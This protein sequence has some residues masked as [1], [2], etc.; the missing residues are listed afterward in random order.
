MPRRGSSNRE[1][2]RPGV[3]DVITGTLLYI[4]RVPS[5]NK[6][7]TDQIKLVMIDDE[8]DE[9][10]NVWVTLRIGELLLGAGLIEEKETQKGDPY[11][12]P[13]DQPRITVGAEK[14][15]KG[16]KQY[17][18]EDENGDRLD[19]T[20]S[21]DGGSSR[22]ES[23]GSGGGGRRTT[24]KVADVRDALA[25]IN[26]NLGAAVKIAKLHETEVATVFIEIMKE[27]L[28][29]RELA[30][31]EE[32]SRMRKPTNDD[33]DEEEEKPRSRTRRSRKPKEKEEKQESFDDF[34]EA[35]EENDDDDDLPF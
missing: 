11:L 30:A 14:G 35:L 12:K 32:N 19:Q 24:R 23:R 28:D 15:D 31:S 20:A 25:R 3:G 13:V 10:V 1:D 7:Y 34:P 4:D 17:Y 6:K 21:L 5:K 22:S 27:G 9:E 18:V 2:I 26:A 8:S 16:R 29:C 33:D